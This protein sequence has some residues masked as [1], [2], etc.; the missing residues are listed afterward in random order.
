MKDLDT[1]NGKLKQLSSFFQKWW[2]TFFALNSVLE[3]LD[4]L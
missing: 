3:L 4:T 1:Q 2:Q